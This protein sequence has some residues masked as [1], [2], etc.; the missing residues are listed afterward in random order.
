MKTLTV[1]IGSRACAKAVSREDSR[2]DPADDNE[3][4]D[5]VAPVKAVHGVAAVRAVRKGRKGSGTDDEQD[6]SDGEGNKVGKDTES[7]V[8]AHH[9]EPNGKDHYDSQHGPM[10]G[11]EIGR[12]ESTY[13]Q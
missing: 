2:V 3:T 13:I 10:T 11:T 4:L 12:R 6:E 9:L 8:L 5:D 1:S 7:N